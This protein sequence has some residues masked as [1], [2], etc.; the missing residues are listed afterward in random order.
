MSIV[1]GLIIAVLLHITTLILLFSNKMKKLTLSKYIKLY[2][3]VTNNI[4][5]N[6]IFR[7]VDN[8]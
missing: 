8:G 1:I 4:R 2:L 7:D 3:F 5:K 6:N